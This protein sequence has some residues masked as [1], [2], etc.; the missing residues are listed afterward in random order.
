M[1]KSETD[2][3]HPTK[4]YS[5]SSS[6]CSTSVYNGDPSQLVETVFKL[7]CQVRRKQPTIDYLVARTKTRLDRQVV[8]ALINAAERLNSL[9]QSPEEAQV[10]ADKQRERSRL[11]QIAE[12]QFIEEFGKLGYQYSREA[13]QRANCQNGNTNMRA[14]PDILFQNPVIVYGHTCH[15][16]EFK[17]YFGFPQNPFVAASEKRQVR[18]YIGQLG[19]GMLV[20]AAGYQTCHLQIAG[21]KVARAVEVVRSLTLQAPCDLRK[22]SYSPVSP[23]QG[24]EASGEEKLVR[25]LSEVFL[26]EGIA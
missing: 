3:P 8:G 4:N 5:G 22:S 23:V 13:E 21:L 7:A 19:T 11:A 24:G 17:D 6:G 15:W 26:H 1:N 14:T 18:K 16:I 9:N 25:G 12:D 10:F 20:Y 2:R